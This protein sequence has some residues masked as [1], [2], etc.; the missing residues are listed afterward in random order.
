MLLE[1]I[2]GP[3]TGRAHQ[4]VKIEITGILPDSC[5]HVGSISLL[6]DEST[7]SVLVDANKYYDDSVACYG[8]FFFPIVTK[9]FMPNSTGTYV[10]KATVFRQR[11]TGKENAPQEVELKIEVSN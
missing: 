11:S 6:V 10:L 2:K 9:T 5:W 4:P 7:K 1:D 3:A 8:T